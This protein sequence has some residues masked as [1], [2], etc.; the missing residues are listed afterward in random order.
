[1]ATTR[2]N[3]FPAGMRVLAIDDDRVCL[4]VLETLLR[5]CHYEVTSTNLAAIALKML[6][7]NRDM[8]DLVISDVHMPGMDGFQLLELVG[9]EMD[10]PVIMLSVNGE[11]KSVMKG[12][13]HGACDYLL[14]PVR[15]EEPRNIWQHVVRRKLSAANSD[16]VYYQVTCGS[17]EQSGRSSYKRKTYHSEEEDEDEESNVQD[18]DKTYPAKKPRIVWT[19]QMHTK[20]VTV[21]NQLGID[22][23][24]PKRILELMNVKD[25]TRENVASHLQKYRIHLRQ[26]RA[27]ES[28][29]AGIYAALGGRDPFLCMYGFEGH[30][31]Y[32]AFFTSP[33]T[34]SSSSAHGYS[35]SNENQQ[36][37]V[38]AHG[39]SAQL[40]SGSCT[41]A[42]M[43]HHILPGNKHGNL[44]QGVA[45]SLQQAQLQQDSGDL[46]AVVS[47]NSLAASPPNM[48]KQGKLAIQP[49]IKVPSASLE[50]LQDISQQSVIPLSE[51]SE[52]KLP[53]RG[54][55]NN[56]GATRLGDT[57]ASS[58]NS[59]GHKEHE[60][61]VWN[62]SQL[63]G[64]VAARHSISQ[65]STNCS[66]FR[67][68]GAVASSIVAQ[69]RAD[70]LFSG[71]TPTDQEPSIPRLL[72]ELS[73]STSR[74][75][76]LL[77][78]VIKLDKGEIASDNDLWCEFY[79]I[80]A[81]M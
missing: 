49:S 16:N 68:T 56:N 22:K 13:T 20:F 60:S 77:D 21:V 14:K 55:F 41:D 78:S 74:F 10:L 39:V 24:V 7:E 58:G 52:S 70:V 72:S 27:L 2:R 46:S 25:L 8:F 54:S 18:N 1:M 28:Y 81:C 79:P 38:L 61:M 31:D 36:P 9:Q 71:D 69:T 45:P 63:Q 42:N 32:Q 76:G 73:S 37:A 50:L 11:T 57:L 65:W 35:V 44:E 66:I 75:D 5:R 40:V 48:L 80:E 15:I 30:Q 19:V 43:Y 34:P 3:Q 51:S 47:G 33:T 64:N 17:S 59:F 29:Q 23:A 26:L 6:R 62:S 53:V 12:I 4:K 67:Q